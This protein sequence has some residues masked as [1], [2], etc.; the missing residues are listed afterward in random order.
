[1][2]KKQGGFTLVELLVVIAII[3][4]LVALLLPAVQAAR[5]AGR[6]SQCLNQIKQWSLGCHNYHD[7]YKKLP[8]STPPNGGWGPSWMVWLTPYVEQQALYQRFDMSQQ[9]WNNAYNDG[10]ANNVNFAILHCPSSPLDPNGTPGNMAQGTAANTT[11]VGIAGAANFPND[12]RQAAGGGGIMAGNGTIIANGRLNLA[13]LTD[14]T[15]NVLMISE[16]STF[17]KDNNGAKQDWRG[18]QPHSWI[19]GI[20]QGS[21]FYGGDN[22]SFNMTSVRYVINDKTLYQD[23][24]GSTGVGFNMGCNIPLK[25]AH[26]GGVLGGLGDGSVQFLTD[27]M[28]LLL[29]QQFCVRDDGNV[30]ALP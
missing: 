10:V 25:S 20:N 22:R 17:T 13:A 9:F 16:H 26:P 28:P 27:T 19:M 5:E 23:N 11:Y 2:V 15:S 29:L 18:S 14:G 21:N 12:P 24:P 30:V 7:T 4:I 3:G 1:M 8:A 6:R